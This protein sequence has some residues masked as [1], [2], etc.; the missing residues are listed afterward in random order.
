MRSG[1]NNLRIRLPRH[2]GTNQK[3]ANAHEDEIRADHEGKLP[4]TVVAAAMQSF[5]RL[6][7]GEVA[8]MGRKVFRATMVDTHGDGTPL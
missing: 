1:C 8:L 7:W 3:D 5:Q 2:S 6:S 4:R